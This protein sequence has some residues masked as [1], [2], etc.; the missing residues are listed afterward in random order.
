MNNKTPYTYDL[1]LRV[2]LFQTAKLRRNTFVLV[3]IELFVGIAL[4]LGDVFSEN[5]H[6][7]T[8][9][10]CFLLLAFVMFLVYRQYSK[11][12][13]GKMLRKLTD[14]NP[15]KVTEYQFEEE[16]MVINVESANVRSSTQVKYS[17][18]SQAT[19]IDHS[20]CYFI[21][22]NNMFYIL[23]DETG[24]EKYLGEINARRFV[25]SLHINNPL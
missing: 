23:Y 14:E 11:A 8:A 5:A 21:T 20:T 15:D 9:G 2:Q 24:I 12:R 19:M 6:T 22:K 4:I 10:A 17:Y 16:Y 13:L 25:K 3:L 18:I 1:L 7:D